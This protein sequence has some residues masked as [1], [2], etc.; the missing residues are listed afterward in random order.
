MPSPPLS[1]LKIL[2]QNHLAGKRW[3]T[4][5]TH[6]RNGRVQRYPYATALK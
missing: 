3:L 4:Y 5:C 2:R 6:P 1:A